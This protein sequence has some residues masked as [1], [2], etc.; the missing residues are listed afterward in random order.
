MNFLFASDS[1]KGSLS[2]SQISALLKQAAEAVFPQCRCESLWIAD[3]G[4]GTMDAVLHSAHGALIPVAAHNPFM[5]PIKTAFGHIDRERAIVEMAQ[6]SGLPL[7]SKERLNPLKASSFG[8]GELIRAALEQGYTDITIAVGGS[9]TNDGGLGCMSA[10]GAEFYDAGGNKLSGTGE[11]LIRLRHIDLSGLHPLIQNARFTVMCDVTNPL[12]GDNGATYTFGAQKGG[13]PAMLR[14]LERGM[15]NYRTLLKRDFHIDP[16]EVPGSGAAGGL[17]TA[18]LIFLH[19]RLKSGIETVLDLIDF[20][21]YLEHTDLV[22]TGEGR[23]DWQSCHGKVMHGIGMHCKKHG[24]P[25][26]GIVGSMGPDAQNIFSYGISSLVTTV[27]SV[28]TLETAIRDAEE[29]Y[30]N[31]ALRTFRILKAGMTLV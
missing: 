3:G 27:N 10:L 17:S 6:A 1:F 13:T 29:L 8:T 2:S 22:I 16:N 28:M 7:I 24:V 5:E 30:Y 19:A 9:A 26:I 23:V 18:L 25:A 12:C 14:E 4:E 20:D 11:D 15:E 21:R 31:A